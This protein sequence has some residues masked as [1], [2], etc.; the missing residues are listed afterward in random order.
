MPTVRVKTILPYALGLPDGDYD[1]A[2]AG[3]ETITVTQA[4]LAEQATPR[5]SLS[6][7]FEHPDGLDADEVEKCRNR[8]AGRLLR[9][10]NRL[11][12][13]CRAESRRAEVTERTRAQSSPFIFELVG[14]G[15]PTDWTA[16][17]LF[18][19]AGPRPLDWSAT[20]F[21]ELVRAGLATGAE[22][23]VDVLFL[24]DAEQAVQ[25]GRFREAVLFSWST[26]DGV[27][28]REYERLVDHALTGEWPDG[29][30]WLKDLKYGLKNK[31]TVGMRLATGRSL[32]TEPNN[33]WTRLSTSYTKRNKIIHEG[34]TA[35]EEDATEAVAVAHTVVR[36]MREVAI[37][38]AETN[39]AA[40]PLLVP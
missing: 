40:G 27:F 23:S 38:G 31:M 20:D 24:L 1:T 3:E 30:S 17:L 39:P 37:A 5:T 18:E 11:L 19:D 10:V 26:I 12:R 8:D 35:T 14:T 22:P 15:D 28:N 16:P 9:R 33:L 4:P 25:Q 2:A 13:W 32:Y 36:V 6:A 7:T 34:Q 29:R 21:A